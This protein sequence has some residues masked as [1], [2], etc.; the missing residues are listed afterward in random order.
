[1]KRS[2]S[3]FLVFTALAGAFG[4]ATAQA[5]PSRPIT[6]VVPA[7]PG[8][9]IDITARL[10]A[11][12][13][14]AA[15]GQPVTIENKAGAATIIGTEAVVKA[16]PDGYTLLIAAS[17]LTINPFIFKKLPYDAAKALDPVIQTHVVP[18]VLVVTA[19]LPVKSVSELI[20]YGKANP[21]KLSYASSGTGAPNFMAAELLKSVSGVPMTHIPYKGSTAAHPD[22]ITGRT[23][24][25]FDTVAAV[26]PHIKSG[27]VRALAVTSLKRSATLADVPTMVEAG[28]RDYE[29]TTWGGIMVPAGT[30]REIISRLNTEIEKALAA[31][32]VRTT[33][34][35]AGIDIGGGSVQFFSDFLRSE[36]A[37]WQKVAQTARIEQQ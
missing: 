10:I 32:D 25:M 9:A 37:R 20:A 14:S 36:T 28:I 17:T 4:A 6:L 7:G 2:I 34:T 12:K 8:G 16:A 22:L 30:P 31:P 19:A 18:L 26:A 13:L 21:D 5:W 33:M 27:A 29:A 23:N 1:M 3:K 15:V 24:V 35:N 11:N